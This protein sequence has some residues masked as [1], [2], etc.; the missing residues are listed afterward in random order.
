VSL[1]TFGVLAV[2]AAYGLR[3]GL[4]T[5]LA[6]LAVGALGMD[7]FSGSSAEKA[8]LV[9]MMGGTGGYLFGF[10]LA[11]AALGFLAQ[12][13]WDRSVIWMAVAM[14]IG[15]VAI[16][17]PGL[18]WLNTFANGWGQTMAWGLTPFIVGDVLKLA[19]AAVLLPAL[20]KLVGSART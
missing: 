20:W 5:V 13:G 17:V 9:Y 12:R 4:V 8:G 6:Y 2:G 14:M 19:L 3:L 16:Y 11:T 10:V 15:T 1:G 18:L 7:V